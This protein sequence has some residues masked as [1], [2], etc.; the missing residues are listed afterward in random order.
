MFFDHRQIKCYVPELPF[1]SPL[2]ACDI[3]IIYSRSDDVF[4]RFAHPRC[5]KNSHYA[6]P[7]VDLDSFGD[8]LIFSYRG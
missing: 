6:M 4:P 5:G 7:S 3:Y 2:S 1:S 8:R